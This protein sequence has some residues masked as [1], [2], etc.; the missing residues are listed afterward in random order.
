M[1]KCREK[2]HLALETSTIRALS[3]VAMRAV[4]AGAIGA[5]ATSV[6]ARQHCACPTAHTKA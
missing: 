5:G 2:K 3:A 4:A 1:K 6:N